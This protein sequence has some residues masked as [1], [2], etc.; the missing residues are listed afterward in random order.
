MSESTGKVDFC[1]GN[2]T[3][4]T[5]YRVFGDLNSG[6]RPVVMLHGGPGLSHHYVLPYKDL[7]TRFNI[8]VIFYDQ[9]GIGESSHPKDVPKEFWTVKLFMD[10][11]DNI[12][13]CLGIKDFDLVGHS[14][15]GMLAA[16][17]VSHRHPPGLRRLVLASAAPSMALWVE[18]T[19]QLL[20]KLP[21]NVRETIEKHEREGSTDDP[22]YQAGMNV[23]YAKHVCK[24][25]PWPEEL[26]SSFAAMQADPVV[27]STMLGPSEFTIV[28]TLKD[29]SCL[30]QIHTIDCP[31]LLT[32]GADDE[33]QDVAV[34]PFF[35]KIPKV[36]WVTFAN[37]SHMAFFEER[38]RY[39]EIVGKFLTGT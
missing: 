21:E 31:T 11:L 7:H 24:I 2:E 28:G 8:P 34:Q 17:Y 3:Y 5:W 19:R 16:H 33:A 27:Y 38:D 39:F 35:T 26:S 22:E 9:I 36:R 10:E 14:W 6:I 37:S 12:L 30:D 1:V 23:F 32:N 18:S 25:T 4:Q 15:G 13:E 20:Q 29:W